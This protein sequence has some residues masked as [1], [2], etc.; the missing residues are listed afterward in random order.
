MPP[1][2]R[3]ERPIR[4][5]T[6]TVTAPTRASTFPNTAAD[7]TVLS[8]AMRA[9]PAMATTMPRNDS[10]VVRS[11]KSRYARTATKTGW[12]DTRTTLAATLV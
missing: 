5:Y 10:G 4:T 6:A 1:V 9:V 2:V 3:E 7:P 12:V 11:P 8:K